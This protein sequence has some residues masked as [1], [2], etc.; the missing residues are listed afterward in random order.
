MVKIVLDV[1]VSLGSRN[2]YILAQR[3]GAYA[4]N[5]AEI[6]SLCP[7]THQRCYRFNGHIEHLRGGNGMN[8][9]LRIKG[10]YHIAV[11]CNIG[12][13]TQFNLRIV[14]INKGTAVL[15]DEEFSH[16]SAKLC[17]DGNI[18]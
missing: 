5:Y 14:G 17:S 10:I 13:H 6:Y 7:C 8:I 18:L 15:C 4:V 2:A 3:E 16:L 1:S 12:K 9:D 11:T